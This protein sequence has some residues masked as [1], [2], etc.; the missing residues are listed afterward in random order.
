M[1]LTVP[2]ITGAKEVATPVLML[3]ARM[4]LRGIRFV[5]CPAPAGRALEKLPPA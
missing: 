1:A 5:P 2:L 3:Y 4:L